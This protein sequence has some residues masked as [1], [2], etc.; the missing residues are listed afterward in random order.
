MVISDV[1]PIHYSLAEVQVSTR[2]LTSAGRRHNEEVIRWN[3]IVR[4]LASRNAGRMIL[5]D[6]EHGSELWIRPDLPPM[7]STLIV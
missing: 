4:N 3:N 7:E 5:M 1:V 2:T 6:I